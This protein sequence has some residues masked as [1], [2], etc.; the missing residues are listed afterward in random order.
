LI[1]ERASSKAIRGVRSQSGPPVVDA[2]L[3][4]LRIAVDTGGTFTDAVAGDGHGGLWVGKALTTHEDVFDGVAAALGEISIQMDLALGELLGRCNLFTYATTHATNAMLTG[5]TARTAFLTTAGFPDTLVLREG[6]KFGPFD[7]AVPYPDPYVPRRLTFEVPERITSEGVIHTPLDELALAAICDELKA[8]DVEA[9]GVCLL[10]S[11]LDPR[12]ELAVAEV[13][14]AQLPGIPYT[15]SHQLNP[16][17]REYRRA[18]GACIDASLKPLMARH[19][20]GV[21]ERLVAAGLAGELLVVTSTGGV[22]PIVDMERRPILA[23]NSGPAIAPVGAAAATAS[24]WSGDAIVCD[25]GGTSFDASLL[26]DGEVGLT[27]ET[28][29]GGQFTGHLT[30]LSSVAV[31]SIGY[32]GGS[33]AWIDDGGLLRV[34]PH[35][36]GSDPGPACYGRGGRAPT[37]TDAAVVLGYIDPASFLDGR[38]RLDRAAALDAIARE[39]GDPLDLEPE[40]AAAAVMAL[41]TASMAAALEGLTIAQGLDPRSALLIGGGGASGLC[42][43]AIA[44]EIGARRVLMPATASV[45]SAFGGLHSDLVADFAASHA[46]DTRTMDVDAVAD[47]LGGLDDEIES[48]LARVS[49]GEG[50]IERQFSV[51][52]RYRFQVWDLDVPLRG[53]GSTQTV[54]PEQLEQAFHAV[55]ERVFGVRDEGQLVECTTWRARGRAA[56]AVPRA[57]SAP[58]SIGELAPRAFASAYFPGLGETV[59]PRFEGLRIPAGQAVVGPAVIEL[60]ATTV[61]VYPGTSARRTPEGHL[62]LEVSDEEAA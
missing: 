51:E 31:E 27:S 44:K 18:S 24:D 3:Q 60:P 11:V 36:A 28:W 58:T 42:V 16:V 15:L 39:I 5:T 23:V 49:L 21:R 40:P 20:A 37:V 47:V 33:V 6:G 41:A 12:H 7:H 4:S 9:V 17:I 19:F 38:M 10:W 30:G 32:G 26:R 61:V 13:L 2:S 59:T 29:L 56:L 25:M 54:D 34:G 8:R 62:L 35:S 53:N 43:G 48:F 52:A 50:A 1:S 46:T 45:L 55:H 57:P 22:T 14:E